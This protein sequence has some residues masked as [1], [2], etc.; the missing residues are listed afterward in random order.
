MLK[1]RLKIVI[2]FCL[3]LFQSMPANAA[4]YLGGDVDGVLYSAT[5]FSYST[6]KVYYVDIEF[7]G[8]DVYIFFPNGGQITLALDNEE[9][10]DPNSISAFDF[11][12]SSYW[13]ISV[14]NM[15]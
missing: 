2:I 6:N 10:D 7:S 12:K 9:I 5:A 8:N 1:N 4:E 13:E 3:L 11:R 14:N 15:E